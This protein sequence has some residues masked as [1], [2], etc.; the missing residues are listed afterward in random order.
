MQNAAQPRMVSEDIP[1]FQYFG[2][3]MTMQS[4]IDDNGSHQETLMGSGKT[5]DTNKTFLKVLSK[6]EK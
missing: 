6:E 4:T 1:H 3:G 5:R 2:K